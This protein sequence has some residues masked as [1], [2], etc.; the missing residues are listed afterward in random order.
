MG[1]GNNYKSGC[2]APG[3]KE[4]VMKKNQLAEVIAE[5]GITYQLAEDGCYYPQISLKQK[6]D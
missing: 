4:I 6:T 1:T 3:R 5:D 2:N